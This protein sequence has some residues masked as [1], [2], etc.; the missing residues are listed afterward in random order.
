MKEHTKLKIA[1]NIR[2]ETNQINYLKTTWMNQTYKMII[3]DD[4]VTYSPGE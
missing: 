1:R 3:D 4:P 2:P